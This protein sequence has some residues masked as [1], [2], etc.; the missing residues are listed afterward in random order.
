MT[1]GL[2][3]RGQPERSQNARTGYANMW[4][5]ELLNSPYDLNLPREVG[6]PDVVS[7][8]NER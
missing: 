8:T 3:F 5:G 7:G 1:V 6:N 4:G 2:D